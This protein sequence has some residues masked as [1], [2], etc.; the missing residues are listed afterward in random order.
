M[1]RRTGKE[2]RNEM[3][4]VKMM[5]EKASVK[6][7]YVETKEETMET[8]TTNQTVANTKHLEELVK[9]NDAI[10]DVVELLMEKL[11][12]NGISFTYE[13]RM[14]T[15]ESERLMKTLLEMGAV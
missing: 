2:G 9:A 8:E 14:W 1:R 6:K 13:T 12:L 5:R 11:K 10:T 7:T 3:R 4:A 15:R